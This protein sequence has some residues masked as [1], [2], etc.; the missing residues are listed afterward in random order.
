MLAEAYISNMSF[1]WSPKLNNQV[2]NQKYNKP[3]AKP[4][5]EA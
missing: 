5:K 3:Q 2:H 4:E 1:E